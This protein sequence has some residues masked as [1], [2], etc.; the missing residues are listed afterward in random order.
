MPDQS[1]PHP[2][3]VG[4]TGT[5]EQVVES[6]LRG[7]ADPCESAESP[8]EA[9]VGI[10]V[11]LSQL[12]QIDSTTS[13]L[14]FEEYRPRSDT[15]A[16]GSCCYTKRLK[17]C[18]LDIGNDGR[19]GSA[20]CGSSPDSGPLH[21]DSPVN[22]HRIAAANAILGPAAGHSV[23][24]MIRQAVC[25]HAAWSVPVACPDRAVSDGNPREL[26]VTGPPALN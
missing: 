20:K 14:I 23:S 2:T 21:A 16:E 18:S 1:L 5:G 22:V 4:P 3:A 15:R 7:Y 6:C 10:R 19:N 17:Q 8:N 9:Q 25:T 24:E 13:F 12:C 11:T 26:T